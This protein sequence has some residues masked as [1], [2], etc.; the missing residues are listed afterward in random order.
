LRGLGR[1]L[2]VQE[3]LV[4]TERLEHAARAEFLERR[5]MHARESNLDALQSLGGELWVTA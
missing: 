1:L 2:D 5:P 4:L 3:D